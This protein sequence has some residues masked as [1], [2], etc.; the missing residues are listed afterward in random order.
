MDE[1]DQLLAEFISEAGDLLASAEEHLLRLEKGDAASVQ[2]VFRAVHTIKG[3]SSFVGLDDINRLAH[4]LEALLDDLRRGQRT[5]TTGLMSCLLAGL[6]RLRTGIIGHPAPV[7]VD[8]LIARIVE[9]RGGLSASRPA[10]LTASEPP[11]EPVPPPPAS[12]GGGIADGTTGTAPVAGTAPMTPCSFARYLVQHGLID[13]KAVLSA[14]ATQHSNAPNPV[15]VMQRQG[16]INDEQAL[17]VI[18]TANASNCHPIEVARHAGFINAGQGQSVLETIATER[19][20]L[21]KLL[22]GQGCCSAEQANAWLQS[23]LADAQSALAS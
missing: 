10:V 8:D 5:V 20:P 18:A 16:I 15:H 14:L 2:A 1:I 7:I 21:T 23:Y 4:Q 9:M 11:D 13:P 6:D 12:A 19:P 17:T 22:V 3:N